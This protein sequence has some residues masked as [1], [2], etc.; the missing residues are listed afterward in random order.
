M[1]DCCVFGGDVGVVEDVV[2]FVCN[3]D[4]YVV[5]VLFG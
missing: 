3:V 1:M 4:G 2:V 5:V